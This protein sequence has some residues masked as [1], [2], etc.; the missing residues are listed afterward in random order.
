MAAARPDLVAFTSEADNLTADD[1]NGHTDAFLNDGRGLTRISQDPPGARITDVVSG[2]CLSRP[3]DRAIIGVTVE[4]PGSDTPEPG[5]VVVDLPEGTAELLPPPDSGGPVGGVDL[6][7]DGGK[8]AWEQGGK[9][10]VFSPEEQPPGASGT[11]TPGPV[12]VKD[13]SGQPAGRPQ[14]RGRRR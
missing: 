1:G 4:H 10:Y 13:G 5:V 12:P 8:P 14:P 2:P 7:P 6:S 11:D 9:V 3:G